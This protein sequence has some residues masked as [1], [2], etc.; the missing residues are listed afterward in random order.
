M[1]RVVAMLAG[2]IEVGKVISKP[3][4][5]TDWDFKDITASFLNE[6]TPTPSSS[7]K[8]RKSK[9]KSQRENPVDDHS[10][11]TDALVSPVNVTQLTDILAEGR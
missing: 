3:S 2:D 9:E 11:G 4:Y 10:E 8:R 6:D 1:S 5:L 7:I